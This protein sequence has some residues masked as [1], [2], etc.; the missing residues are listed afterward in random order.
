MIVAAV[1][2]ASRIFQNARRA[3]CFTEEAPM[4]TIHRRFLVWGNLSGELRA[5]ENILPELSLF[6]QVYVKEFVAYY[7]VTVICYFY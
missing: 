6:M 3:F 2:S 4:G 5:P 7:V 1:F